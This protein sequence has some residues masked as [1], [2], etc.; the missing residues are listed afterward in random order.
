[1]LLAF[2]LLVGGID[3]TAAHV[4]PV[5]PPIPVV[6]KVLATVQPLRVYEP[7]A[8]MKCPNGYDLWWP[9]GKEFDDQYAECV[10]FTKL[11]HERLQKLKQY[12]HVIVTEDTKSK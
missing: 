5:T 9:Y 7:V 4:Q 11:E 10:K 1:M 2:A 6:V 8:E 3:P 12:I